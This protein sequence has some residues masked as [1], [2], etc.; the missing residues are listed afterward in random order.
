MPILLHYNRNTPLPA[1]G[2]LVACH[3]APKQRTLSH[4]YPQAQPHLHTLL[5]ASNTALQHGQCSAYRSDVTFAAISMS[6]AADHTTSQLVSSHCR[7]K[8]LLAVCTEE[9]EDLE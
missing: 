9:L 8:V 7:G 1:K 6:S 3:Q 2:S 4:E 5:P